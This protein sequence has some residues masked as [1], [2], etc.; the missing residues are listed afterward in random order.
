MGKD[1][2][3]DMEC[4]IKLGEKRGGVG[5]MGSFRSPSSACTAC[6]LDNVGE[7]RDLTDEPD[8]DKASDGLPSPD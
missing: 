1:D 8:T 7:T 5:V 2:W 6:C 3:T 4:R